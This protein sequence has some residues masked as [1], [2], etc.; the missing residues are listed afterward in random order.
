MPRA[1]GLVATLLLAALGGA[2]CVAQT[3]KLDGNALLDP[4]HLVQIKI[5]MKDDDWDALRKQ[6]RHGAS[7]FAGAPIDD[8][9]T[10]FP[11][12][13]KIDGVVVRKVAVR[14]KGLFG[15][16]DSERPSLKVKFDEYVEQDPIDGLDRMT[17]NNNKQ[18]T[19]LVSQHL[20]YQLFRAAG[21][22]APRTTLAWVTLNGEDLGIYTHVESIRKP[23]LARAFGD[24]SG[25]LYEGTLT[26]F[27]PRTL[28][29]FA[30]TTNKKSTDRADLGRIAALFEGNAALSMEEVAKL[31]DVD[32][33]L[34]YWAM[35]SMVQFWDGYSG[36]QNNFYFYVE[37]ASGRGSFIPWGADASFSEKSLF[38]SAGGS[39]AIYAKS[40][41]CNRIYHAEGMAD[42]YRATLVRLLDEVWNEKELLAEIDRVQ[43]LAR[44]HL[45]RSQKSTDRAADDVRAYIS[46][47]R[48]R[49]AEELER[50]PPSVPPKPILPTYTVPLGKLH[51]VFATKWDEKQPD[52][53]SRA[54]KAAL[55]L[56]LDGGP[57]AF[58]RLGVCASEARSNGF[59]GGA[60]GEPPRVSLTVA[61]V[62]AADGQLLTFE[63]TIDQAAFLDASAE[64][65]AVTGSFRRGD[66]PPPTG[67]ERGT[68]TSVFG[69]VTFLRAG[70]KR[71]Q[72]V[73]GELDL[74]I[75]EVHGGAAGE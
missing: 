13:I 73:E 43:R 70:V 31:I 56:T 75:A 16:M 29:N 66:E 20:T 21:V 9:F 74:T 6:R 30:A 12:D 55:E 33:F 60:G 14:K 17:L 46:A 25:N 45:H 22:H 47:R 61:G 64:P 19:S 48:T 65:I 41:L 2:P 44:P 18:D 15:S 42:R 35:E 39:T 71:G 69:D 37:P 4:S 54:G 7:L 5:T 40:I 50:W 34:K 10:W 53:P 8:P 58:K 62:R 23:F 36:N 24:G 32:A 11:A 63:I 27:H 3:E 38:R 28:E 49:L 52:D 57:V 72:K 26:D 68:R 67:F 51:G 1:N 59:F